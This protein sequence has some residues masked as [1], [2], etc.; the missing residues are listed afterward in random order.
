MQFHIGTKI[1]DLE[2][3]GQILV[4]CGSIGVGRPSLLHAI[5]ILK[6][7]ET[8]TKALNLSTCK[9]K[10]Q[11]LYFLLLKQIFLIS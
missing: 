2:Q 4:I 7:S 5:L 11:E 9:Y 10:L 6:I 1:K 3:S 8:V